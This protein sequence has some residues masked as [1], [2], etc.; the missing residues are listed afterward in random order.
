M[1]TTNEWR[2]VKGPLGKNRK[3]RARS[4]RLRTVPT[5]NCFLFTLLPRVEKRKNKNKNTQAGIHRASVR[6]LRV[7]PPSRWGRWGG[8]GAGGGTTHG[9]RL[10]SHL[11]LP[12]KT[13]RTPSSLNMIQ[14]TAQ[15]HQQEDESVQHP[16]GYLDPIS[17]C[18]GLNYEQVILP[19]HQRMQEFNSLLT[20]STPKQHQIPPVK[21]YPPAPPHYFR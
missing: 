6:V 10:R 13:G 12:S 3:N 17:M 7:S 11:K 5:A 9:T 8:G 1:L 14:D 20:L 16:F 4:S 18:W 21:S 15:E 19:H 2:L